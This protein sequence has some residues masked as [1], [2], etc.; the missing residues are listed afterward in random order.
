MRD[1]SEKQMETKWKALEKGYKK[2]LDPQTG[3][4]P[5]PF[6]YFEQMHDSLGI[7]PISNPN[8]SWM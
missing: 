4:E 2:A 5:K 6:R 8:T 1:I 3:S 7:G